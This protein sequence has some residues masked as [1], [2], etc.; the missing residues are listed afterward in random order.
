MKKYNADADIADR[1]NVYGYSAAQT[2]GSKLDQ[3]IEP[4]SY[5]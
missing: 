1:F 4:A 2:L 3:D 5:P